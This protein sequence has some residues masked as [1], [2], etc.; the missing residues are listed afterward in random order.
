MTAGVEKTPA[1]TDPN[2]VRMYQNPCKRVMLMNLQSGIDHAH[3]HLETAAMIAEETARL[4][5]VRREGQATAQIVAE[6]T[7]EAETVNLQARLHQFAG[8]AIVLHHDS[9]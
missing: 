9:H 6:T 7:T 2:T 4:L 1:T 3:H 8:Q 5:E